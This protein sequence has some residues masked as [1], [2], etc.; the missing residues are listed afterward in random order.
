MT[1][2]KLGTTTVTLRRP[3]PRAQVIICLALA[4]GFT[5]LLLSQLF[6]ERLSATRSIE[7]EVGFAAEGVI[8]DQVDPWGPAH[9]AGLAADDVLVAINGQPIRWMIDYAAATDRFEPGQQQTLTVRRGGETLDLE[10]VPGVDFDWGVWALNGLAATVHMVFGLLVLLYAGGDLRARLLSI[11]LV[12]IGLELAAPWAL[13]GAPVVSTVSACAFWLLSGLQFGVELHLASVIPRPQPW[14]HS[15]RWPLRL[16]YGVGIGFGLLMAASS[17]PAAEGTDALGWVFTAWGDHLVSAFFA[18]WLLGL[19]VVLGNAALRWPEPRG[20]QQALLVLLGV[21][22]WAALMGATIVWDLMDRAYPAW[23]EPVEPLV[24]LIYPVAFIFAIFR[25]RLFDL[26][27]VVQRSL[28]YG[29]LSTMLLLGAYAGLTI[30]DVGFS[31][32]LKG[33][34]PTLVVATSALTLGLLFSPLKRLLERQVERR[35]FPERVALRERLSALVRALP[36]RGQLP[37]M[38]ETLVAELVEIFAVDSACLLLADRDSDLLVGRASRH[39]GDGAHGML[40]PKT[41]PFVRFLSERGQAT[42]AD[43]WP[44][45]MLLTARFQQIGSALAVPIMRSGELTGILMLG[46][47]RDGDEFGAEEK[48]LLD[49]LSHHVATVLENAHL[50][51]TATLDGLTRLLRREPALLELRREIDRARRYERPLS[52]AMVDVDRFKAVND[53]LGH[54]AGDLIL[55]EVAVQLGEGLRSTDVLGR[56]GGEEF[57]ALLPETDHK[58]A[59]KVAERMRLAVARHNVQIEGRAVGV[60]VSIGLASLE[61]LPAG[62]EPT[63]ERLIEAADRS[64]YEAKRAGR[65]RIATRLS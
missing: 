39:C 60:T 33:G 12:A 55:R 44:R 46:A 40:F 5:L 19:V 17:L 45:T 51:E 53:V 61:D 52:I 50:F 1:S 58:L 24:F 20:R 30:A 32:L 34:L 11:L 28:V 21:L 35:F 16:F 2:R 37:A 29:A 10:V 63:P 18:A 41:D 23:V 6:E 59:R 49:L 54:V 43:R 3:E 31:S 56:Y 25:Y 47:R 15:R 62:V 26:E 9:A 36:G 22:P 38:A 65:N 4:I 64:L 42:S 13:V 27:F 48:E 7:I 57:L 8:V 14:L